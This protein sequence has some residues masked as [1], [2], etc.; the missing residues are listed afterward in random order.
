MFLSN[1]SVIISIR[2]I[3]KIRRCSLQSFK[4]LQ[5]LQ[6]LQSFKFTKVFKEHVHLAADNDSFG[7]LQHNEKVVVLKTETLSGTIQFI[8]SGVLT[9]I[10]TKGLT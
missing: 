9:G 1:A 3:P 10:S 5:S 2:L 7:A 4:F 6:S 8:E